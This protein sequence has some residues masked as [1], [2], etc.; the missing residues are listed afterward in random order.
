MFFYLLVIYSRI[1][2]LLLYPP[3]GNKC[4][5]YTFMSANLQ[6]SIYRTNNFCVCKLAN[7]A[8]CCLCKMDFVILLF[9]KEKRCSP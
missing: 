1:E 4:F 8:L 3:Y 2:A 7:A 6:Y 9:K 5:S